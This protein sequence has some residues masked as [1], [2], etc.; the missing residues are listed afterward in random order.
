MKNEYIL[1]NSANPDEMLPYAAF[2]QNL[3]ELCLQKYLFT[4]SPERKKSSLFA[5]VLIYQVF[6]ST[7]S[8]SNEKFDF[9]VQVLYKSLLMMST[10]HL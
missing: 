8:K 1:A 2:H 9:Y 4:N 10:M 6:T 7:D 5:K 3:H